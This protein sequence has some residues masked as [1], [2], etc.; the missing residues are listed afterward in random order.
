MLIILFL[1]RG[2]FIN[3]RSDLVRE[4]HIPNQDFRGH[5]TGNSCSQAQGRR[6]PIRTNGVV[7]RPLRGDG[8]ARNV[9]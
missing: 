1:F 5:P 4:I 9:L 2:F 7:D 6:L 8:M 3:S